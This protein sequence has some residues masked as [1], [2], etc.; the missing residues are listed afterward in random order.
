MKDKPE[1]NMYSR[2]N[3]GPGTLVAGRKSWSRVYEAGIRE[4]KV[5]EVAG[6]T[7]CRGSGWAVA[8]AVCFH[9]E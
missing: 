6:A 4:N 1:K 7:S 3:G 5:R 8:R 2:K 9:A